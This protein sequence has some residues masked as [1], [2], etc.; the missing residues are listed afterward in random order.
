MPKNSP[1]KPRLSP[2]AIPGPSRSPSGSSPATSMKTTKIN[3]REYPNGNRTAP[4][5][6]TLGFEA[7]LWAAADKLRGHMD[8]AEYKHVVLGLIFLK[9][10]SD[11]FQEQFNA[12][13][14]EPNADPEDRDEY[15]ANNVFWVP[16]SARWPALQ[17]AAKQT[18]IGRLID[19]AMIA[20]EKENISLKGVLPKDYARPALD[21]ARLGELI[22]LLSN[23]G[24]GD[25]ESRSKDLLGRV[26]EYFLGRFASAEGK[27]GGEFYTP[28]CIVKLL[29]E[30]I[31]PYQGRIFDPCCGS[32]GMFVQSEK[33]VLAHGGRIGDIAV[34]GQ[35]SNPT[36]WR[37]AKMNLA[38]RGI[39]ANLGPHHADSFHQDLHK[40]LK[41]D[42]ILA[43]PPFNM[44]DWGADRITSDPRW[45]FGTPPNG[46]ANYAWIQHFIHHLAPDGIAGFVLANGSMSTNTSGEGD[47]RQAIIEAD[48]VDC[49][50]ALPGQLFYTT[51]I[52]VCL[53]FITR[54]KSGGKFRSRKGE[55]LFLDAR[56]RGTMVDRTHLELTD[57]D[58]AKIAG[59][60][61]AWRKNPLP[62]GEGTGEGV[63]EY[64]DIAGFCKSAKKAEVASHGYILTP[65]R[66]VGAADIADD[67]EPFED[68]MK[69]LTATLSQQF[70]ESAK[71]EKEIRKNLASL[72]FPLEEKP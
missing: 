34:Y 57:D 55:I 69:R 67:G 2:P 25:A 6:T 68:K 58:I 39:D 47:I 30:M 65:G 1:H 41:A 52:P 40:D 42:F 50:I 27:G 33:F 23:I 8:S 24:L 32:G 29:A 15:T 14:A 10:I 17:A 51:Q 37:L 13:R 36:T 54:D 26:Y 4:K 45:K 53:W 44:S 28:A 48:L 35:E 18:D 20:I 46:N 61:H 11:S 5:P 16:K 38:I 63:A 64:R 60:Y 9:Y 72:G 56:K 19:D 43:N 7:T 49:M 66:Y 22:D 70:A 21:K 3:T 31:E 12:L 62:M 59:T 71:L